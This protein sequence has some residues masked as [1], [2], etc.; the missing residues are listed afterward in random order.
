MSLRLFALVAGQLICFADSSLRPVIEGLA[1]ELCSDH[2]LST[3]QRRIIQTRP[4]FGLISFLF[5]LL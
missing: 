1:Q 5:S 4:S 2:G 3:L